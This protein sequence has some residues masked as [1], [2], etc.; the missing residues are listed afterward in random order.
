MQA[1]DD[2]GIG[3]RFHPR[4]PANF[5]VKLLLD[6]KAVLAKALDVSMAGLRVT[7]PEWVQRDRL[8]VAVPL[9]GREVV[10][11]C[12]VRRRDGAAMALEF[13]ELDWEDMFALARFLHPRLP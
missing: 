8:T 6:G 12:R 7:G 11:G 13:D 1:R 4:V 5:M 9:P 2:T 3:D 10:A